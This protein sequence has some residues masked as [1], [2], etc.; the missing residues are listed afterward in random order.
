M[1]AWL[2]DCDSNHK[3]CQTSHYPYP[4]RLIDVGTLGNPK[5]RLVVPRTDFK[6]HGQGNEGIRENRWITLS[7]AWGDLS[8]ENVFWTSRQNID[9]L[10]EGIPFEQL[11]ATF[12]DAVTTTRA[13]NVRYLWIDAICIVYGQSGDFNEEAK[14][15]EGVFSGAHCVIAASRATS[16]ADGFLKPRT[17]GEYLTFQRGNQKPFYMCESINNFY[18]DVLEGPLNQRG[19]V[20]QERALAR[21]T[22]FFTDTQTYFECG[23]GVR[24]E[25]LVKMHQ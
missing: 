6:I 14:R 15:M 24:C 17:Q 5:L 20:L 21:R 12:Q 8:N 16:Q 22:I 11:P 19:W 1:R 9:F 3:D 13:L 25:T 23:N 10:R 4:T 7:H 2:D 18:Q